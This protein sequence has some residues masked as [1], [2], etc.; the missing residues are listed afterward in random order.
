MPSKKG[1][2][3]IIRRHQGRLVE[4]VIAKR[5]GERKHDRLFWNLSAFTDDIQHRGGWHSRRAGPAVTGQNFSRRT[6]QRFLSL[7]RPGEFAASRQLF[8]HL[9]EEYPQAKFFISYIEGDRET[10]QHEL[11]HWDFFRSE[12][13]RRG[14]GRAWRALP[15]S[16]RTQLRTHLGKQSDQRAVHLDEWQAYVRT[17]PLSEWT[18]EIRHLTSEQKADLRRASQCLKNIKPH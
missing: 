14:C 12:A 8:H 13:Y 9:L 5:A 4:I 17:V 10:R 7:P 18:E 16:L 11:C 1:G 3:K 6:L 15:L 2:V